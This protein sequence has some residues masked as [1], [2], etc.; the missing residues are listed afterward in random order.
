MSYVAAKSKNMETE[1]WHLMT[2]Y[3]IGDLERS[4]LVNDGRKKPNLSNYDK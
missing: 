3:V 1:G 2:S 4:H